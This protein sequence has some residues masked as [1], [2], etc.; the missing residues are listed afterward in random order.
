M[1][2]RRRFSHRSQQLLDGPSGDLVLR[3]VTSA[4]GS[5]PVDFLDW[6]TSVGLDAR[7]SVGAI[8]DAV[9]PPLPLLRGQ[10]HQVVLCCHLSPCLLGAQTKR[11]KRCVEA[12]PVHMA[13]GTC[14]SSTSSIM[15][16]WRWDQRIQTLS[17]PGLV[18]TSRLAGTGRAELVQTG[19]KQRQRQQPR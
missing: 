11:C 13:S 8:V 19:S 7:V 15:A 10:E 17:A 4:V 1:E 16:R 3:C 12:C 6:I 5:P 9:Q 14:W 2:I 18:R